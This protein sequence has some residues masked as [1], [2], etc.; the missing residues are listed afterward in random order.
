MCASPQHFTFPLRSIFHR[1][2]PPTET[3]ACL[4]STSSRSLTIPL[5]L[6]DRCCMLIFLSSLWNVRSM[7]I[8][9]NKYDW[10]TL[11]TSWLFLYLM[12]IT[13]KN[14]SEKLHQSEKTVVPSLG[15]VVTN[16]VKRW[17]LRFSNSCQKTKKNFVWAGFSYHKH[18]CTFLD[19]QNLF[20]IIQMYHG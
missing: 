2:L 18:R 15:G 1:I 14:I 6:N 8:F 4:L 16:L 17:R 5:H 20:K 11:I 10:A 7:L 19:H 13:A 3:C 12:T 9:K